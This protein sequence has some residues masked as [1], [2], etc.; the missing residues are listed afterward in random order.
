MGVLRE[1]YDRGQKFIIW[2]EGE[3][4]L[5]FSHWKEGHGNVMVEELSS[6]EGFGVNTAASL[7]KLWY[8]EL[9]EPIFPQTAYA[10]VE[11]I[12]GSL[13]SFDSISTI[14]D[15]IAEFSEWSPISKTS[16]QILTMHLLP[17]LSL[18]AENQDW[19]QMNAHNLAVCIA[20]A[21]LR[22]P[23]ALEDTQMIGMVS[24]ILEY[25][26]KNWKSQLSVICGMN[27]HKFEET[28]RVPEAASDQEDPL[29]ATSTPL[30]H[31]TQQTA[32]IVL[33]DNEGSDDDEEEEEDRPPLPPRLI[34]ATSEP[35]TDG[36]NAPRRKPAPSLQAPPRYSTIISA[37]PDDLDHLPLYSLTV[38]ERLIASSESEQYPATGSPTRTDTIV[39]RKPLPNLASRS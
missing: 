38:N 10:Y 2:R 8:A 27:Q 36:G 7:I 17:L 9:R 31:D 35:N 37:G 30:M 20:P 12:C 23:D 28:L 24:Q 3:S 39:P 33:I 15:L 22:G 1:A 11:R 29:D 13:G 21:L 16:R 34:L 5:T 25:A 26:V 32:G 14:L 6:A 18:V 19:N 4:V